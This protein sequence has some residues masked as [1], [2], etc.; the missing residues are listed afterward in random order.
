MMRRRRAEFESMPLDERELARQQNLARAM[1]LYGEGTKVRATPPP[2]QTDLRAP[3]KV[4]MMPDS[5]EDAEPHEQ[6]VERRIRMSGLPLVTRT[7][8]RLG[9]WRHRGQP[10]LEK[11]LAA[12]KE[13]AE[14]KGPPFLTLTGPVGTGKSHLACAIAW[15]WVE[16][17]KLVCY[18]Q[19]ERLLDELR[20]TFDTP[21]RSFEEV[22][23]WYE[24][25]HLLVIDDLGAEHSSSWSMA[26]LEALI[27][28]RYLH[29]RATVVT[30]NLP[31]DALPSRIESR[32]GD[33]RTGRCL[34]LNA[35]DY[36]RKTG[37]AHG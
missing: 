26:K 34:W 29:E 3:V 9:T 27:D 17:G 28:H 33:V 13:L 23:S 20:A 10:A 36:R 11:A 12:S 21:Q 6:M 1:M 35:P 14:G 31:L 22:M 8:F 19:A 30:S 37:G 2:R 5:E 16:R 15:E 7:R 24:G 4:E 25:C 32:L 18:R